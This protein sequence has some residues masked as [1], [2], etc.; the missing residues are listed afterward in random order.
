MAA[1]NREKIDKKT[2]QEKHG[3]HDDHT[4]P[5]H[6]LNHGTIMTKFFQPVPILEWC[7]AFRCYINSSVGSFNKSSLLLQ[8]H[9]VLFKFKMKMLSLQFWKFWKCS[10][11]GAVALR[12]F[13]QRGAGM[14]DRTNN[15]IFLQEKP[16]L[17]WKPGGRNQA[18]SFREFWVL[19]SIRQHWKYNFPAFVLSGLQLNSLN[20]RSFSLKV[21]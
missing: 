13:R 1:T 6:G 15:K 18:I 19:K 20:L 11:Q 9:H 8:F 14:I 16:T 3:K 10:T 2:V 21:I 12:V 17:D 4:Y 5:Y 7:L